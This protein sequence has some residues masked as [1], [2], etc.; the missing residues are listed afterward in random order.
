LS[1][2]RCTP[3]ATHVC[4]QLL[5][6]SPSSWTYDT[7]FGAQQSGSVIS[8]L[9]ETTIF[10]HA[11]NPTMASTPFGRFVIGAPPLGN[12]TIMSSI[13]NGVM[14]Y[15]PRIV[16]NGNA[17]FGFNTSRSILR[18][19]NTCA[20][21]SSFICVIHD[22]TIP[23]K[24]QFYTNPTA[25]SPSPSISFSYGSTYTLS[26]VG[27][28]FTALPLSLMRNGVLV[29]AASGLLTGANPLRSGSLTFKVTLSGSYYIVNADTLQPLI[30]NDDDGVTT[31]DGDPCYSYVRQ[32]DGTVVRTSICNHD[33]KSF[34]N[35]I[36]IAMISALSIFI[37]CAAVAA[38]RRCYVRRR[39]SNIVTKYVPKQSIELMTTPSVGKG[40]IDEEVPSAV[41]GD[42]VLP[43]SLSTSSS[44]TTNIVDQSLIVNNPTGTVASDDVTS[45]SHPSLPPP[46]PSPPSPLPPI[47][48]A[49]RSEVPSSPSIASPSSSSTLSSSLTP[50]T[51]RVVAWT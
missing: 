9:S 46:S 48:P 15:T 16:V 28:I 37:V 22:G 1:R 27:S 2:A 41:G 21:S 29:N 38:I 4:V 42:S 10:F 35:W 20:P 11:P 23:G 26:V 6:E 12:N 8:T 50:P 17:T 30:A 47:S 18:I 13:G 31:V 5:N 49:T 3:S 19:G 44:D 25:T 14:Q 34:D 33:S 7:G 39:A 40:S 51:P 36:I 32:T 43:Q 45:M 24:L